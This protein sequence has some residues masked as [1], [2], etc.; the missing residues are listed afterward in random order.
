MDGRMLDVPIDEITHRRRL[1]LRGPAD[2]G[3]NLFCNLR[4]FSP[5][6]TPVLRWPSHRCRGG[7]CSICSPRYLRRATNTN[8]VR[9]PPF[10]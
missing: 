2:T 9:A 5:R 1:A 10:E 7:R 4:Q 6:Q 3:L 8:H